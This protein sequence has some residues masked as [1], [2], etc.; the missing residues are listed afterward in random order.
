MKLNEEVLEKFRRYVD[1]AQDNVYITQQDIAKTLG[2]G[3][4]TIEYWV[5]RGRDAGLSDGTTNERDEQVNDLLRRFH[6]IYS[7]CKGYQ[8]SYLIKN[9][10]SN[11]INTTM[12]IFLL[13]SAH[14]YIDRVDNV[15]SG[16]PVFNIKLTKPSE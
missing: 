6:E 15:I 11:N 5:S 8:E 10:L 1:D 13:K 2:V 16:Q 4:R 9:G 7:D 14:G 3:R 12:A